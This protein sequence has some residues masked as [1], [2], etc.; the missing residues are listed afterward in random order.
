MEAVPFNPRS[1]RSMR[2][3]GQRYPNNPVE[4]PVVAIPKPYVPNE[5]CN[6]HGHSDR[7]F[8]FNS[9][10]WGS[11]SRNEGMFR[12]EEPVYEEIDQQMHT[13]FQTFL[14]EPQSSSFMHGG[15][16][17]DINKLSEIS[18]QSSRNYS[19][20]KP[21]LTNGDAWN[22]HLVTSISQSVDSTPVISREQAAGSARVAGE[23]MRNI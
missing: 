15:M 11:V 21:L 22:R 5:F 7:H 12:H 8:G 6:V 19:D 13:G 10:M 17:D 23:H 4:I 18:R 20:N 16:E 2:N 9:Y 1:L 14:C 3:Q